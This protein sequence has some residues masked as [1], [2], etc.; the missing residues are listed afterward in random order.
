MSLP[1]L[2]PSK[3]VPLYLSVCLDHL[4]SRPSNLTLQHRFAFIGGAKI[5]GYGCKRLG[6]GS[7]GVLAGGGSNKVAL[8][9]GL[10]VGLGVAL[11]AALA[12][13]V[14]LLLLL[15]RRRRRQRCTLDSAKK[16]LTTAPLRHHLAPN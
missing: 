8:G 2:P 14:C 5:E 9:V 4:T 1:N 3:L 15:R 6:G 11:L 10:G 12:A 7:A 16:V 13:L